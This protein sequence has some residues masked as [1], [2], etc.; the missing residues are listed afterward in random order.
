MLRFIFVFLFSFSSVYA[1]GLPPIYISPD[2]TIEDIYFH[3][4]NAEVIKL[5]EKSINLSIGEVLKS[6]SSLSFYLTKSNSMIKKS[7]LFKNE[8]FWR[9]L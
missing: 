7:V 9:S 6:K 3:S 4:G 2:P 5:K 8:R 1:K